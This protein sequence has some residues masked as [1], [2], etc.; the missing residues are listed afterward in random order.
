MLLVFVKIGTSG[1]TD[2]ATLPTCLATKAVLS[3]CCWAAACI[4]FEG[5]GEDEDEDKDEAEDESKGEEN[6][7]DEKRR[8]RDEE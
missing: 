8:G 6:R 4:S 5:K 2:H 3:D 1:W 7:R